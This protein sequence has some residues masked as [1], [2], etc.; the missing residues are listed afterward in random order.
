MQLNPNLVYIEQ[1][2]SN[3]RVIALQ[4]GTRSGK[5]YSTLQWII[6]I[7]LKHQGMTV[8][9]VR[10]TLPA[11][12]ASALRDFVDIMIEAG[13]YDESKHNKTENNY[14]LNNN[15][16]E[17]FSIDNEQKLRGRKRHILFV[18]EA[19]EITID[20]W[21]QLLLRTTGKVIIDYN[22]SMYDSWIYDEVLTRDDC[23]MKVTTYKDNPHLSK[24]L[25]NEIE[26]LQTADPEYWKVFGLGERGMLTNIIFDNWMGVASVPSDARLVGYAL[27]FGYTND[28]TAVIAAYKMDGKYYFDEVLYQKGLTNSEIANAL[29][30]INKSVY[31]VCDS[32]E[33]KSIQ[34]L[35][36]YGFKVEGAQKGAD[37]IRISIDALKRDK[38]YVTQR[39]T[40]LVK[41]L[42][43]YTWQKD[44]SGKVLD[45][46]VD[47][48]N[49]AI[50]AV[51]YFA[52]NN[53]V[54]N[55]RG[56]YGFR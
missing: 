18:N 24:E 26:R 32:A 21:R 45:K 2:I 22:P 41:E 48:L 55:N 27:D 29:K 43:S 12:K 9:V 30:D 28:P 5:T 23:G 52:L 33:P 11:L 1:N 53:I 4:G 7:C 56:V 15:L 25:V 51:R 20:Q 54:N 35:A 8:S 50:D 49:H 36:N 46:P 44:R 38:F 14:I 39:S 47:Y 17:F 3:K 31:I 34:E 6:R 16:I 37:S 42:R 19:N 10:S 40:N 13:L